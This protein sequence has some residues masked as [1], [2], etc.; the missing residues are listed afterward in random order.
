M[1]M[2]IMNGS[3]MRT[4]GSKTF[5]GNSVNNTVW[6]FKYVNGVQTEASK[7]LEQQRHTKATIMNTEGYDD[8][9]F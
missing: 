6:P 3:E 1:K 9:L 4:S 5:T 2:D 7:A 8:A